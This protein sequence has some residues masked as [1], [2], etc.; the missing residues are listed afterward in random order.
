MQPAVRKNSYCEKIKF[1]KIYNTYW[2]SCLLA[3]M[4][5]GSL[6][7]QHV[8][9]SVWRLNGIQCNDCDDDVIADSVTAVTELRQHQWNTI[10]DNTF[11]SWELSGPPPPPPP[12]SCLQI[13]VCPCAVRSPQSSYYPF[14]FKSS[15]CVTMNHLPHLWLRLHLPVGLHHIRMYACSWNTKIKNN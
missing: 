13:E 14:S 15:R 5:V 1:L 9:D 11:S 6:W 10:W 7:N 3:V 2:V 4:D 12:P 8:E